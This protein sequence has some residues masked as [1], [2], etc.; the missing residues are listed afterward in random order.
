VREIVGWE[1]NPDPNGQFHVAFFD[2]SGFNGID[3][4]D[5]PEAFQNFVDTRLMPGIAGGVDGEPTVTITPAHA[6]F[7]LAAV[8]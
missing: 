5:S 8:S 7:S 3:V 2:E 6:V 1:T 4:W